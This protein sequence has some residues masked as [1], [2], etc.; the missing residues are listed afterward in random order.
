MINLRL[1][2]G[3]HLATNPAP[4]ADIAKA[5]EAVQQISGLPLPAAD[6]AFAAGFAALCYFASPSVLDKSNAVLVAAVVAAFLV[7]WLS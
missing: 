4:A 7:R 1:Q 5:G 2:I 3:R 6:A